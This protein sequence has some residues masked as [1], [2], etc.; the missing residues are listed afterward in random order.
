MDYGSYKMLLEEQQVP[1]KTC[2]RRRQTCVCYITV[3]VLRSV[4]GMKPCKLSS[5]PCP[6]TSHF[7][8][9]SPQPHERT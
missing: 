1:C 9:R 2:K 8:A 7:M 3:G 6:L 5:T 4:E